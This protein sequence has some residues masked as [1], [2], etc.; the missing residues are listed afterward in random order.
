MEAADIGVTGRGIGAYEA[1]SC[2]G[3]ALPHPPAN[4]QVVLVEP[5][6]D[7]GA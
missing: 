5:N 2:M 1:I 3:L 4:V 7:C 6:G